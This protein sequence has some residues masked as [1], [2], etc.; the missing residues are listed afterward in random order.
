MRSPL[1][2]GRQ[3][4]RCEVGVVAG[5]GHQRDAAVTQLAQRID[6]LLRRIHQHAFD[7][8]P[9]CTFDR[10]F[11]AAFD[12]DALADARRRIQTARLQPRHRRALL[13]AER[14]LLQGFQRRQPTTCGL[15]LLAHLGQFALACPLLFLQPA[16]RVLARFD[17]LG[18]PVQRGLLGFVA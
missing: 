11:P 14:G 17:L 13:L 1:H 3:R 15:R 16:E 7:Q 2:L 9:Q 4:G 12:R 18:Q 10:I 5:T 8:L 6:Q